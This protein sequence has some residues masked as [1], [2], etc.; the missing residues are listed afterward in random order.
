M[1]ES[2]VGMAQ[3]NNMATSAVPKEF[4]SSTVKTSLISNLAKSGFNNTT[5]IHQNDSFDSNYDSIS[6]LY[7]HPH[8]QK[9]MGLIDTAPE[10]LIYGLGIFITIVC[11]IGVSG[12]ATAMYIFSRY[13]KSFSTGQCRA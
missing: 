11:I 10:G 3:T 13:V 2:T 9:Y 7:L 5:I 4:A 1:N 6:G 8:W 12:N